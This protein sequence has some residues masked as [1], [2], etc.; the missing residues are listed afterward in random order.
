MIV[1]V[2][3]VTALSLSALMAGGWLLQIRTRNSGWA[4]ALWSFEVGFVGMVLALMPW[5]VIPH[6]PVARRLLVALLV[7]IW[8]VRL[9]LNVMRRVRAKVEDPRYLTLREA[10]KGAYQPRLF[11]FLQ[12]QALVAFALV[13]AVAIAAHNPAPGI[14]PLDIFGAFLLI[15]ALFGENV[16]DTQRKL[17]AAEKANRSRIC[18]VGLWGWSQNPDYFFQWLGWLA[19]PLIAL[20]FSGAYPLGFLALIGPAALFATL[21]YLTGVPPRETHMARR[22][23]GNFLDYRERV[24]AFFPRPP[25]TRGDGAPR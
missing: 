23:G 22:H 24:S 7:A 5:P 3:A 17:F 18:D 8:S 10:W 4:D 19:C 11:W 15:A 9:G 20:D 13:V 12:V 16:A 25:R 14:R 21:R 6:A 2:L 1:T